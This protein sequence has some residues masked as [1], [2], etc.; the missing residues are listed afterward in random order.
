MSKI[1]CIDFDGTIVDHQYPAIGEIRPFAKEAI[2]RLHDEGWYIIIW[3][4]RCGD[5]LMDARKWLLDNKIW[6]D[7][8]NENAP[9]EMIG[10]IPSPK[11]YGD[12]YI[13]DRNLE[14]V[15]EWPMI[16]S[17]ITGNKLLI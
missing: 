9:V 11:V 10:F 2:N 16:Y 4:C 6:F 5:T 1:L 17:M 3:T 14:G 8:L 13:D 7:K 15:P 12:I